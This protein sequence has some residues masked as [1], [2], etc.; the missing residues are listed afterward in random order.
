M[1]EAEPAT[2]DGD[3]LA[4]G[5]R[6]T[7]RDL[8]MVSLKLGLT[9]FGGPAAHIAMLHEEVVVRRKW[10][11]DQHFL[12]LLGATN[13]IPGPNSTEMV[14]HTG[15]EQGRIRGMLV[16]GLCFILPASIITLAFAW[17]Y[18][19]YGTMP[20]AGWLL[21]GV[22]PVVIAVIASAIWSLVRTAARTPWLLGL[23][24]VVAGLALVGV[25]ELA[26]LFGAGGLTTLIQNRDAI[27]R[28]IGRPLVIAPFLPAWLLPGAAIVS[29]AT[30][31]YS[32]W[33]LLLLFLRIGATLY[34]SGYVLIAFIQED[35]VDRLGWLTEAQLIDAVAVGQLTPGPVSSTATFVGYLIGGWGGA[36]LATVG[37][38]L[39]A[40]VFVA[41]TNPLLPRLRASTWAAGF[42]DGVSVAAVG[43]MV[44]VAWTLGRASVIDPITAALAVGSLLG[45]VL[46][47]VNS[48]WLIVGGAAIGLIIRSWLLP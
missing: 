30:Q 3:A 32:P 25:S 33:Q 34:G 16:A 29:V 15:Y 23:G 4:L 28:R 1:H 21:Y 36:A 17:L 11:S 24:A 27:S 19:R 22:K 48:V 38:F 7:T 9:A 35:L 26:L 10:Q 18:V 47:H 12:D 41:L 42:L 20:V 5:T 14:I 31:P 6:P 13:L 46:L 44:A 43:L 40:F 8:L 39:P 45:L 37:I 2:N